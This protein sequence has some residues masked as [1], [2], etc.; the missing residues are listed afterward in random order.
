MGMVISFDMV[1]RLLIGWVPYPVFFLLYQ[2]L[3]ATY[4]DALYEKR[5]NAYRH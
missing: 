5:V 4:Q 3:Q 1:E 2:M